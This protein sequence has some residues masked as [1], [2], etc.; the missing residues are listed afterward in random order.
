VFGA[1]RAGIKNPGVHHGWHGLDGNGL[2]APGAD[3]QQQKLLWTWAWRVIGAWSDPQHPPH[4]PHPY[5]PSV[6]DASPL[7]GVNR[8]TERRVHTDEADWA[9]EPVGERNEP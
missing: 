5:S 9:E 4:P 7:A 3:V 1:C 2:I 6:L 8:H